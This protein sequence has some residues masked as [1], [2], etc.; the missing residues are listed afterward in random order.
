ME[1]IDVYVSK[2]RDKVAAKIFFK[3]CIKVT[4]DALESLRSNSHHGYDQVKE[5]VP[6]TRHHKV[7][8]LK[9]KAESS[10]V[11]LKQRY[12]PMRGFKNFDTIEIFL[13]SFELIYR[14]FQ[15]IRPSNCE[16][17]ILHK[18]KL[19]EFNVILQVNCTCN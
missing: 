17:R 16:I 14:F 5:I 8:C 6:N 11:P 18:E 9:N 2:N 4:G 12:R 10:H 19:A 15:R 3:K 1:V 7:K 13:V